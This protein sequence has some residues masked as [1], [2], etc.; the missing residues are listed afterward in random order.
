MG[1]LYF[2][3][4]FLSTVVLIVTTLIKS[5]RKKSIARNLKILST[6]IVL[7]LLLWTVSYFRSGIRTVD[8]GEDICFDDWC[9]TVTSFE[10]LSK[11]GN[12]KPDGQFI[13]VSVTMTN[14]ARG[15]SQKPSNPRIHIIDDNGNNWAVSTL[16]QK[17]F[18][19]FKGIQIPI[20]ERLELHQSL[21]TKIVFDIP[22]EATV[23]KALI[24]EG[25]Q[26]MTNIILPDDK[27]V[28]RLK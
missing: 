25:P 2:F 19:D 14:K 17:W 22:K 21:Q 3:I 4:T 18:E 7:Y 8:F 24:E 26:F 5:I 23:L 1:E 16:A 10:R 15:I 28:F 11:I 12:Q 9:A 13:V 20:D 6:L 27:K